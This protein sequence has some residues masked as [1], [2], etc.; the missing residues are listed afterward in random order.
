MS[1][2]VKALFIDPLFIGYKLPASISASF[3]V[4][5]QGT[6][7]SDLYTHSKDLFSQNNPCPGEERRKMLCPQL[8]PYTVL[9]KPRQMGSFR[10]TYVLLH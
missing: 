9:G 8:E 5:T 7:V 4:Y 10:I 2:V 3:M 6:V 1:N